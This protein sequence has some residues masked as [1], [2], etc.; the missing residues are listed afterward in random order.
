MM[1]RR[2]ECIVSTLHF[3]GAHFFLNGR[4]PLGSRERGIND[5]RS[6]NLLPCNICLRREPAC[7]LIAIVDAERVCAPKICLVPRQRS[8]LFH[9][10]YCTTTTTYGSSDT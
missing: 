1:Q 3:L 9:V 7:G 6:I 4:T 8:L 2:T 10:V 5:Q